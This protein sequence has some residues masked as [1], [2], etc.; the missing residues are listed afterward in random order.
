MT[1]ALP[2]PSLTAQWFPDVQTVGDAPFFR[3]RLLLGTRT[4]QQGD[5]YL[6]I[7]QVTLPNHARRVP[8]VDIGK[9]DSEMAEVGGYSNSNVAKVEIVQRIDHI[10][11][12]NRARYMPQNPDILATMSSTGTAFVL[13]RTKHPLEPTGTFKPD[14]TLEYHTEEGYGLSWSPHDPG[15]LLSGAG[16]SK[17]ALW[18]ITQFSSISPELAPSRDFS[19]HTTGVNEV[20]WHPLHHHYFGSVSDDSSLVIH[21]LRL[22]P[23]DESLRATEQGQTII[24]LAFNPFNE[25]LVATGSSDSIKLWDIRKL[26]ACLHT[27][28]GHNN[29]VVCLEWS[30]HEKTILASASPDRRVFIWDVALMG[31]EPKSRTVPPE[32][33]FIHGGH[34]SGVFDVTWN[35]AIPWMLAS[36]ADDNLLHIWKPSNTIVGFE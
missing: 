4:A 22:A 8:Q 11:E 15:K 30:P 32:L 12:V 28:K 5:E 18:D 36:V 29:D 35:P 19:T 2:W 33:I 25:Y 13:D 1:A 27:L 23:S 20:Q 3:Q 17:I 16:D 14:I 34:S 7:A 9:Y 21:D 10:G 31:S 24:T 26:P 6:R